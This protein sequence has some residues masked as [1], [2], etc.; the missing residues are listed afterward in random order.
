MESARER[1]IFGASK[2]FVWGDRPA[3]RDR[4][5]VNFVGGA[6]MSVVKE[7]KRGQIL[8]IRVNE[9]G[10]AEVNVKIPL[11]LARWGMKVGARYAGEDLRE[12]GID[13]D[14]L[15]TEV[16][17]VGKIADITDENGHVEIFVE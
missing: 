10:K 2:A 16:D 5:R 3:P 9:L 7:E 11:G 15:L 13:L 4:D 14:Q 17:T 1:R 12:R 6:V 8:H